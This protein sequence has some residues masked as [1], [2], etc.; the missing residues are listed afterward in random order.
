MKAGGRGLIFAVAL[1]TKRMRFDNC[2]IFLLSTA[3][4]TVYGDTIWLEAWSELAPP[5]TA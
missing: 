1:V 5:Q 4:E 2:R 3:S